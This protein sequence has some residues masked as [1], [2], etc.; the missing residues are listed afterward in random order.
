MSRISW[1]HEGW[2]RFDIVIH[3]R[4]SKRK[5]IALQIAGGTDFGH[6]S[7]ATDGIA[8]AVR[9]LLPGAREYYVV[10]MLSR[11]GE[12]KFVNLVSPTRL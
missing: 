9:K 11:E 1:Q 12:Y 2:E 5:A 4:K 8:D 6:A 10:L 7:F 3:A